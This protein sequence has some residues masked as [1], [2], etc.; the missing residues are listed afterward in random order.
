MKD[1]EGVESQGQGD[2]FWGLSPSQR[3]TWGFAYHFWIKG[4][5]TELEG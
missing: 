4:T 2:A 5:P 1:L 3:G